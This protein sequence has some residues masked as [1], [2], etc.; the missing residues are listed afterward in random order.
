MINNF[1][2]ASQIAGIFWEYYQFTNDR[3]FLAQKAY[4]F[5]KKAAE[6]YV[7]TLQWDNQKSEFFIYPSQP[8]E[9]PRSNDLK[10]PIT[11]RNMIASTMEACIEGA[12]IL[13]VDKKKVKEW[14]HIIDTPIEP[15]SY[16]CS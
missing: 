12:E 7:Q 6:F 13:G 1:T 3:E 8:Y 15:Q 11:D 14:Q 4:P 2:P 10:N 9:S 5:M 16:Y